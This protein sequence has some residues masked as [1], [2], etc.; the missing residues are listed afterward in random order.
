MQLLL[1]KF[2]AMIISS[3]II[4]VCFLIPIRVSTFVE[5]TEGK[6]RWFLRACTCFGGGVFLGTYMLFMRPEVRTLLEESLMV[7]EGIKYPLPEAVSGAGFFLIFF[8]GK[9]T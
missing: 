1:S 3:G 2:L 7:P 9:Q 4:L 6:G 5:R 8:I